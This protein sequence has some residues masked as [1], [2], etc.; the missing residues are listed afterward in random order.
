MLA[1]DAKQKIE[2]GD[3][4]M[5]IELKPESKI[6]NKSRLQAKKYEFKSNYL[7]SN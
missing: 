3:D 1:S 2:D 6:L 4:I 5:N 7:L